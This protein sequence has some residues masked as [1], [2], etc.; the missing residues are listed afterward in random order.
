MQPFFT[1]S[2]IYNPTSPVLSLCPGCEYVEVEAVLALSGQVGPEEL[3]RSQAGP[4]HPQQGP[5]LIGDVWEPLR[6]DRAG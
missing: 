5:G 1:L 6:A 3:Q 2:L 4:G